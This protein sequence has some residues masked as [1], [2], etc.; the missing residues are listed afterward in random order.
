MLIQLIVLELV[1]RGFN[2][3][4]G[5]VGTSIG[6]HISF[7]MVDSLIVER[8]FYTDAD[9][10]TKA[11]FA[12]QEIFSYDS[13]IVINSDGFRDTEF[14]HYDGDEPTVLLIGD[15]FCWGGAANPINRSF[16]DLLEGYGYEVFNTGIP[17]TGPAQYLQVAQKFLP[18][19]KPD[20]VVVVFYMAND[21][22][23]RNIPALPET[24][25]YHL[26]NAGWMD[27]YLDGDY[28]PSPERCYEYY[29][30]RFSIPKEG[31]FNRIM[32]TTVITTQLW[33]IFEKLGWIANNL[34][35]EV[36]ER[37]AANPYPFLP[38]P[39]SYK[40]IRAIYDL[41]QANEAEFYLCIIPVHTYLEDDLETNQKYLFQ[42]LPY[43]W[44]NTLKF[45]DYND[46]PDGHFNNK[47]HAKY[48]EFLKEVIK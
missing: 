10:V 13:T 12:E 29:L 36:L 23:Y 38:H 28:L 22:M 9:A 46:W 26:T 3:R 44:P 8:F 19:L 35:A 16:A 25:I 7:N 45:A 33:K 42:D 17:G 30:K 31:T 5:F 43:H 6:D 48:A 24:N 41:T 40:Y 15:S 2:H 11:N 4:P 1:L 37:R 47:G 32:A 39:V 27:A 20:K 21:V 14:G 18:K 34:H